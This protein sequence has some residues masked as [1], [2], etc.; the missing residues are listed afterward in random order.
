MLYAIF[1]IER[2]RNTFFIFE[3]CA[4]EVKPLVTAITLS[5]QAVICGITNTILGA[6]TFNQFTRK[7]FRLFTP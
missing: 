7:C 5:P 2:L 6:F 1:T 4:F 3:I